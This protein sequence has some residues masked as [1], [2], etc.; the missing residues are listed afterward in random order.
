MIPRG[1][2]IVCYGLAGINFLLVAFFGGWLLKNKKRSQVK[3]AQPLFLMMVL[4]G[5][6]I[7]TSTIF[8]MAQQDE[9]DGPV[10]A[11]AAIPWLY[12][13][14]FS[15]TFGALFARIKRIHS[16]M[17][18][19]VEM[20]RVT[21]SA[22]K[23]LRTVTLVLAIDVLILTVWTAVD[24]LRWNRTTINI[25][26][27][28]NS[29]ESQGFCSSDH[30]QVFASLIGFFHFILMAVACY[31][32][33]LARKIPDRIANGKYVGFAMFSNLQIFLIIIPVLLIF[34]GQDT[35]ASFFV[36]SAAIW[37]ND[38]VVI[39]LIFGNLLLKVYQ[40]DADQST[41][42]RNSSHVKIKKDIQAY[43]RLMRGISSRLNV[44]NGNLH[45]NPRSRRHTFP[46]AASAQPVQVPSST[47]PG[48]S[49]AEEK[50]D[51]DG[52]PASHAAQQEYHSAPSPYHGYNTHIELPANRGPNGYNN[53]TE[54]QRSVQDLLNMFEIK[55][56]DP[57]P[58]VPSM[59]RGS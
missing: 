54:E 34:G 19:A 51:E 15:L 8:A 53:H 11:C 36:R 26:Q 20:K 22:K 16:V 40:N 43:A 42:Q 12:S 14:G 18:A 55:T 4:L 50:T 31:W 38:C 46:M 32:S 7:S 27:Y 33:Y 28:G 17:H 37:I 3:I 24:P 30:W 10:H 52:Q 47:Q 13:I 6:V 1:V 58:S 35:K 29:V 2:I 21:I 5:C 57:S 45:S 9:G 49:A 56:R 44:S 48:S 39:M 23:I 25:D 41:K 59:F